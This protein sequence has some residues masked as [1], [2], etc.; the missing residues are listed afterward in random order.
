MKKIAI[1][2]LL[3][4]LVLLQSVGCK[5]PVDPYLPDSDIFKSSLK[6]V[7]IKPVY[8][9]TSIFIQSDL[10]FTGDYIAFG[11]LGYLP[12]NQDK[13]ISIF[14]RYT[15]DK[16][17]NWAR[18]PCCI[19]EGNETQFKDFAIGGRNNDIA[20]FSELSNLY[21]FDVSTRQKKWRFNFSDYMPNNQFTTF[22]NKLYLSYWEGGTWSTTWAKLARYDAQTGAQEDLFTVTAIPEYDFFIAP[23]A[24]YV[25]PNQ[26]TL[27]VGV[28]YHYRFTDHQKMAWLYCYNV[29]HKTMKW[30]NK[31]F[32]I[33]NEESR[34]DLQVIENG[35]VLIQT[36]R[37]VYCVDIESGN[38]VWKKEGLTLSL[39]KTK[40]LYEDGK[41]YCRIDEGNIY[42]WDAETGTEIWK[43][44][45]SYLYSV[46]K[47]NF[48]L[49]KGK[50]YFTA[51]WYGKTHLCCISSQS[52]ELLWKD[53]SP[54]YVIGGL[55]LLD[56][57]LGYLYG[58]GDGFIYCLD[59]NKTEM[60]RVND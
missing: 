58:I 46:D 47:D 39:N 11:T 28:T 20:F 23:P 59:L 32:S 15:G 42:C 40:L 27:I 8:Q 37:A 52:G 14:N 33:D 34:N 9:D 10:Y 1:I 5:D 50:L 44:E 6:F 56:K 55:L 35:K 43:N 29:T 48:V 49:Y 38:V 7:W 57:N 54:F 18:F 3:F 26:D 22:D 51:F 2:I 36:L 21:A 41:V 19:L 45:N 24:G 4:S 31:N 13:G 53:P 60:F 30:E 16:H 25:A 12:E 17:P